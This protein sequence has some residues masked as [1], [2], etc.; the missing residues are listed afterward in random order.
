[1]LARRLIGALV[2]LAVTIV[3]LQALPDVKRYLRLRAM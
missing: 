1:M 2:A 3:L